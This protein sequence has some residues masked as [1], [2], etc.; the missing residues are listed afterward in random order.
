M[1]GQQLL[2]ERLLD[3]RQAP[4]RWQ[5]RVSVSKPQS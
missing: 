1:G 3:L 2:A 4:K 5:K